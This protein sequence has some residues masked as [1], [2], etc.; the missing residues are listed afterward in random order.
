SSASGTEPKG[1]GVVMVALELPT[2]M[3]MVIL[4]RRWG[5]G[6][7][8]FSAESCELV[9]RARGKLI[10]KALDLIV[11]NDLTE[12]G[13]GFGAD[14]SRAT[15]LDRTGRCDALPLMSKPELAHRILDAVLTLP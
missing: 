7:G 1:G 4:T 15:F 11:A 13:A 10:D 9:A 12:P 6:V 8:G 5:Q 3:V 14:T 2:F